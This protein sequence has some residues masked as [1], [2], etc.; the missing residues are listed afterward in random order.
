MSECCTK[1]RRDFFSRFTNNKHAKNKDFR[2]GHD[3]TKIDTK[4][5][6][7]FV[8]HNYYH[9]NNNKHINKHRLYWYLS[10]HTK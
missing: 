4:K 5:T 10:K 7:S 6:S 8:H 2:V 9:I 3:E 1:N